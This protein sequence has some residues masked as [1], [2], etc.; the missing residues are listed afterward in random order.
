MKSDHYFGRQN[1]VNKASLHS[2][3]RYVHV[4]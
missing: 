1:A 4:Y 2:M 3:F